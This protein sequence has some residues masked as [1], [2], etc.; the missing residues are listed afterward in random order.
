[1]SRRLARFSPPLPD[2][3]KHKE[4]AQR[5]ALVREAGATYAW[6]APRLLIEGWAGT[7]TP[8][9]LAFIRKHRS[10]AAQRKA[11]QSAARLRERHAYPP[12]PYT[13]AQERARVAL[14]TGA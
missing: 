12:I 5:D 11:E 2:P 3:C 4:C 13:R 6:L 9:E 14:P 1:M 10:E 8:A 7:K